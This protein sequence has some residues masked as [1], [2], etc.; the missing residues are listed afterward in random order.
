MPVTPPAW[1]ELPGTALAPRISVL[2]VRENVDPPDFGLMVRI[3]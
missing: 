3:R 2:P 1:R